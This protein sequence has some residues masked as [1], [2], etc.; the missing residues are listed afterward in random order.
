MGWTGLVPIS[1]LFEFVFGIKP[2]ASQGQILWDVNLTQHHGIKHYPFGPDGELT[3][4]CERRASRREKP[5]IT[6]SSNVP[7]ELEV[8]WG[9]PGSRQS[10]VIQSSN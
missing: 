1:V 9:E 6:L 10:M 4:M 3:L 8:R 7:V 2:D 5:T